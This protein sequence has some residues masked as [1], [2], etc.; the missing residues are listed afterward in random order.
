L[1]LQGEQGSGKSFTTRKLQALIDPQDAE[2]NADP[3]DEKEIMISAYNCWISCFD[4]LKR[5]SES[6]SNTVC[7]IA[8]GASYKGRKLYKDKDL[9]S[10]KVRRPQILNGIT[11]ILTKSDALDRALLIEC[12]PITS[13][14][15]KEK[16]KLDTE[17]EAARPFLLGALLDAVSGA[18]R[19][20]P[21]THLTEME[22]MADFQVWANAGEKAL[23]LV[24]GEINRCYLD[25]Q[26]DAHEL[27]EE[28]NPMIR[29]I[30]AFMKS[31][32]NDWHGQPQE[33]LNTL[34]TFVNANSTNLNFSPDRLPKTAST[35]SGQ[36]RSIAP[37][38]RAKGVSLESKK[39]GKRII[40]LRKVGEYLPEKPKA[41]NVLDF[42][43]NQKAHGIFGLTQSDIARVNSQFTCKI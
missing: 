25:N 6:V 1:A 21:N 2:F 38:L 18:L 19:E 15:R 26:K 28:V 37:N 30:T 3:K 23:G 5:V 41:D 34:R 33:L 42:P 13:V 24:K 39:S 9:S 11:D 20:M 43:E 29:V 12:P 40:T 16:G 36:I 4:N 7:R 35:L 14:E 10:I 22:R 32:K 27:A 8:T 17:F 31:E